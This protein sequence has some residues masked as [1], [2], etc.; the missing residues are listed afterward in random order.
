MQQEI[1]LLEIERLKEEQELQKN[2]DKERKYAKYLEAQR[3]KIAAHS[4]V[5]NEDDIKKRAQEERDR[6]RAVADE[7]KRKQEHENKKK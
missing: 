4:K 3:E 2:R 1:E 7:R 6:K 5:K